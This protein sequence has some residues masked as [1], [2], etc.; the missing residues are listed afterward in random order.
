MTNSPAQSNKLSN[1]IRQSYEIRDQNCNVPIL[2]TSFWL[3]HKSGWILI[4]RYKLYNFQCWQCFVLKAVSVISVNFFRRRPISQFFIW[5]PHKW[6]IDWLWSK[7]SSDLM[8]Q[9]QIML[10]M[11]HI[12]II[13]LIFSY[14]FVTNPISFMIKSLVW[15]SDYNHIISRRSR[16]ETRPCWRKRPVSSGLVRGPKEATRGPTRFTNIMKPL[17]WQGKQ[18]LSLGKRET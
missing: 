3:H 15:I 8:R 17:L 5:F 7:S 18:N 13:I 10:A 4:I 1:S 2:V 11:L 6:V 9:M 12:K 14:M 16:W